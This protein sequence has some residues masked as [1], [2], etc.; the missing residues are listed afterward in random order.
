MSRND[1]T[2]KG[3]VLFG[4]TFN[5]IHQGH[6]RLCC[7]AWKA[8][9]PRLVVLMPTQPF[10]KELNTEASQR[11]EMCQRAVENLPF[12]VAVDGYEIQQGSSCRTYDT[13]CAMKQKFPDDPL[14]L[15]MGSDTFLSFSYW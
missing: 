4:G 11:I 15:L 12:P 6:I 7:S 14:Y 2:K 3:I 8:V 1:G 10:Y 13:L 9:H 5:P